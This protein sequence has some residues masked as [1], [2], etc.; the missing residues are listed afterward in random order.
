VWCLCGAA[1]A[2]CVV[3]AVNFFLATDRIF[4]LFGEPNQRFI[5]KYR[6]FPVLIHF[7]HLLHLLCLDVYLPL[8]ARY[9]LTR[10][11]SPKCTALRLSK[12][13]QACTALAAKRQ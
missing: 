1:L 7:L 11:G 5:W 9:V 2:G 10:T 6:S 3:Q 8:S 4:N 13:L 12:F